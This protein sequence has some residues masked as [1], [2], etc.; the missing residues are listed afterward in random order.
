MPLISAQAEL[1]MPSNVQPADLSLS[2]TLPGR[3]TRKCLPTHRP[4]QS[5]ANSDLCRDRVRK[6]VGVVVPTAYVVVRDLDGAA[7]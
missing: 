1:D 6:S 3:S 2:G 4:T 5:S 7:L